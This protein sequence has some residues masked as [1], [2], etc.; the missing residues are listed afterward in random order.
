MSE[1]TDR[2][3]RSNKTLFVV[4]LALAAAVA[5]GFY[6]WWKT[7]APGLHVTPGSLNQTAAVPGARGD[8]PLA[9]TVYVPSDGM[10][11]AASAAIK[12]QPDTQSQAREAVA[13]VLA[14][15]RAPQAAVL[16]DI[17]L[18]EFYLDSAGTAYIDL[19]PVQQSD[20]RA[21]AWEEM[22]AVYALVNT[23][24]QN[25]EEIKQVRFLLDGREAQTLAGHID[26]SRTYTKRMDLVR[27]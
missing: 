1:R 21:S 5:G 4:A 10:L 3:I 25:F 15:P 6:L 24:M 27:Q 2:A 8:E 20:I 12:R 19:S 17:K 14:D 7:A 13:A 18:R 9:V 22:T 23:L 11:A 26:L 16:K